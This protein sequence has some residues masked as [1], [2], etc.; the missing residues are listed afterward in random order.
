MGF[1]LKFP[2]V[3]G[4]PMRLKESCMNDFSCSVRSIMEIYHPVEIGAIIFRY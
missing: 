3:S 2:V 1:F 4:T